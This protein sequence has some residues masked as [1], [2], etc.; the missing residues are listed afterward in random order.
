M[1]TRAVATG[2]DWVLNGTKAWITN[3]GEAEY[4]TVMA[5]TDP[6]GRR[7]ANVTAF[8]VEKSDAGVS[9]GEKERKLGIK[10]SPTRELILQ[11]VRVPGDRRVGAVG[12]GLKLA[13][14]PLDPPR[15]P[16]GAQAVGI[17]QQTNADRQSLRRRVGDLGSSASVARRC[18]PRRRRRRR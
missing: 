14:Q 2:D 8:V 6:D 4:Y 1:R 7:G 5:V 11:D 9:F 12:E 17:A 10:G 13:L 15:I 18:C 16:L 3:A